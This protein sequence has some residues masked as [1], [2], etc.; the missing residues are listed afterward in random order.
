MLGPSEGIQNYSPSRLLVLGQVD[1]KIFNNLYTQT[2]FF[3]GAGSRTDTGRRDSYFTSIISILVGY[4]RRVNLGVDL[5]PKAVRVGDADSSPFSVLQF[6]TNDRANAA[7]AAVAPKIKFA[8]FRR[9]PNLALQA[10]VYIPL[11]SDLEGKRSGRPFLDYDDVQAW[12]LAFYDIS[13]N[14]SWLLYLEGGFLFRY[15]SAIE[16]AD[17]EYIYPIKGIL[18]HYASNRLTF[19]ALAE[20]TP[21]ALFY[22]PSLFSTLYTQAGLGVKYQITPRFEVESLVTTFPFGYNKG[23][24]Q[25]YNLGFRFVR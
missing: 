4:S 19:Y 6:S 10:S 17:H 5:Y 22:D 1:V 14:P 15:D 12:F 8:P 21:S 24:G 16:R 9:I 7:L 13:F 2:A 3:D 20:F 25:T 18:N 11:A 23:A